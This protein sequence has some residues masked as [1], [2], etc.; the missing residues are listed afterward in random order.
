MEQRAHGVD[1]WRE[2]FVTLRAPKL[3]NLR[4]DPFERADHEAMGYPKWW[5]E[6]MFVMAPA[7]AYVA[8]WLQS[9]KNSRRDK[10]LVPS[11]SV[12]RWTS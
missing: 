6:H 5:V 9:F 2:P 12:T 8:N 10:S 7:Q 11:V 1:V 4:T 3:F